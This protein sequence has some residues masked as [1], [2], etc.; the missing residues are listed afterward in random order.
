MFG[1]WSATCEKWGTMSGDEMEVEVLDE[2]EAE[3]SAILPPSRARPVSMAERKGRPTL[4]TERVQ[5]EICERITRG[6]PAKTAAQAV[7]IS[8]RTFNDWLKRGLE[9]ADD[10]E[11]EAPFVAFAEAVEEARARFVAVHVENVAA[12]GADDWK[13]SAWLLERRTKAFQKREQT[14]VDQK[15]QHSGGVS[16]TLYVPDNGR[17][18]S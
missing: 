5:Y 6:V 16:V 8:V 4:L 7:G 14:T 18:K 10:D 9:A 2:D 3:S 17:A 1:G 13:A 12:A 15:V 11:R